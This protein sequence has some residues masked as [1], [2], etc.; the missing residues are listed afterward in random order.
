[1]RRL[2]A[3]FLIITFCTFVGCKNDEEVTTES[4][5]KGFTVR[6]LFD[7][8][9]LQDERYSLYYPRDV[10]TDSEGNIFVLD[11]GNQRVVKFSPEGEYISEFGRM[12]DGPGEFKMW[13]MRAAIHID[14]HDNIYIINEASGRCQI[15][16]SDFKFL[17]SFKIKAGNGIADLS[18]NS[19]GDIYISVCNHKNAEGATI[20][21]Y[22]KSE[23]GYKLAKKFSNNPIEKPDNP[24][25]KFYFKRD[26]VFRMMSPISFIEHNEKDEL[27]QVFQFHRL[28]RKFDKND[29]LVL[30]KM[31]DLS[32]AELLMST[33]FKD[34]HSGPEPDMEHKI[35]ETERGENLFRLLFSHYFAINYVT[36]DIFINLYH[37]PC[38]LK[39]DY[40]LNLKA[41]YYPEDLLGIDRDKF[42]GNMYHYFQSKIIDNELHTFDYDPVTGRAIFISHHGNM[43]IF[44][45]DIR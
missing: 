27:F 8:E 38:V 37:I 44:V 7:D 22:V 13:R 40:D 11:G 10:D 31:I 23:D 30:E 39:I 14:Q 9:K 29:N 43:N 24:N 4:V 32:G 3:V 19:G 5:D 6:M 17:D 35:I 21:K 1:M 34:F 45:A 16:N 42:E 15:F 25:D 20:Y 12:G 28:V 18:V 36:D 41:A 33:H 26:A 2:F